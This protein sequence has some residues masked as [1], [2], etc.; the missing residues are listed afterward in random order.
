ME[1]V[2]AGAW[3]PRPRAR[4]R[5]MRLRTCRLASRY[6]RR[7]RLRFTT[8]P[9]PLQQHRKPAVPEPAAFRCKLFQAFAQRSI[10]RNTTGLVAE[11]TS[12]A[13]GDRA[14]PGVR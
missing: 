5:R 10:I 1:P 3:L 2:T 4:R 11:H 9:S 13:L 8:M 14:R 12:I 7:M 6:T